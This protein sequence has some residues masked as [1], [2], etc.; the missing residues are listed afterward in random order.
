M[1]NFYACKRRVQ[2]FYSVL[3]DILAGFSRAYALTAPLGKPNPLTFWAVFNPGWKEHAPADCSSWR[4][5]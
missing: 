4:E 3:P 2:G 1:Y 5:L